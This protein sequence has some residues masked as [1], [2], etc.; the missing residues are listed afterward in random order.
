MQFLGESEV[1]EFHV[2]L[3]VD[4]DVFRF[5]VAVDDASTLQLPDALQELQRV[6]GKHA[7]PVAQFDGLAEVIETAAVD[8]FA[9]ELDLVFVGQGAH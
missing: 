7:L 4:H 6:V 8:E 2:A 1:D 5:Q 9:D 3:T